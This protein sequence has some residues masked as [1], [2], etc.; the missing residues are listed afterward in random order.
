MST[1][2]QICLFLEGTKGVFGADNCIFLGRNPEG[3]G[4]WVYYKYTY[5]EII[6]GIQYDKKMKIKIF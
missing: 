1:I 6:N 4:K 2:F 5:R 3:P